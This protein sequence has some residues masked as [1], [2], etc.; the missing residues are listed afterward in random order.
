MSSSVFTPITND[1]EFGIAAAQAATDLANFKELNGDILAEDANM[2]SELMAMKKAFHERYGLVGSTFN[3]FSDDSGRRPAQ[4]AIQRA[5]DDL[6]I[7]E[8]SVCPLLL[9]YNKVYLAS[10]LIAKPNV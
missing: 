1:S 4:A 2:K 6:K 3:V 5:K 10:S 8:E 7:Y 9:N